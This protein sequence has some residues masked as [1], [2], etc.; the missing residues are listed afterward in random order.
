MRVFEEVLQR[1]EA[2]NRYG[3]LIFAVAATFK[4]RQAQS[5]DCGYGFIENARGDSIG[6]QSYF[7][8]TT[9]KQPVSG[10]APRPVKAAPGSMPSRPEPGKLFVISGRCGRMCNRL[11]LFANF[12]A[13]AEEQGH[14]VANP[15]FHSYAK[16]FEATRND[17]YCRYPRAARRSGWDIIPGVGDAIRGTRI[18]F[19]LARAFGLWNERHPIFGKAV[20]TLRETPGQKITALDGPEVQAGIRDARIIFVNGWNFR[21]PELVQRHAEKI[22]PC[23]QPISQIEQASREAVARLRQ[24]ADVVA[25]VVVRH[26]DYRTF[27]GGAYFYDVAQYAAWM[28]QLAGQF[29]G[30]KVAFFVSSDEPRREQEFPGLRVAIGDVSAIG[31]VINLHALARCDYVMGPVSTFPMWASFYGNKP[32]FLIRDRAARI[33]RSEFRVSDLREIP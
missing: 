16:F 20:F 11:T 22:R 32:L 33:E 31:G 27:R 25:G 12:I 13:L 5:E 3:D 18:F 26:G 17:I 14:R 8:M 23:F 19:H 7:T 21:A 28:R 29:P 10:E 2:A 4:S 30:S 15:T 1:H 9:A 24:Q 6:P